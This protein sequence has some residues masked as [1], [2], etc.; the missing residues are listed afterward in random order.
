MLFRSLFEGML[1]LLHTTTTKVFGH[2]MHLWRT[3]FVLRISDEIP[4]AVYCRT[5]WFS[6]PTLSLMATCPEYNNSK[7]LIS[8]HFFQH[9]FPFVCVPLIQPKVWNNKINKTKLG[10][11]LLTIIRSFSLRY[12]SSFR[13]C[14]WVGEKEKCWGQTEEVAWLILSI[15]PVFVFTTLKMTTV[16]RG[17]AL[18]GSDIQWCGHHPQDLRTSRPSANETSWFLSTV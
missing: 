15:N 14:N 6:R 8:L 10:K 9:F 13:L 11:Y 3:P 2:A 12:Y 5:R 17:G 4:S 18:A 16:D 1:Q 7:N